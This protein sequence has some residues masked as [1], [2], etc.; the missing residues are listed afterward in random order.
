MRAVALSMFNLG[1]EITSGINPFFS[2]L[3]GS[4]I[5]LS[6]MHGFPFNLV[7]VVIESTVSEK[8]MGKK[9]LEKMIKREVDGVS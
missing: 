1:R 2:H 3:L 7:I 8:L 6:S 4:E 9:T 5:H